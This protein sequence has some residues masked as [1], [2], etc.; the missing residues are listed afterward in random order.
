MVGKIIQK[1]DGVLYTYINIVNGSMV[2]DNNST[3]YLSDDPIEAKI[4]IAT[5]LTFLI[6]LIQVNFCLNFHFF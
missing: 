6:G 1:Y 5:S 3:R 4:M 2:V